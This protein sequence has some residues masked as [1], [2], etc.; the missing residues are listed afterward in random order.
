MIPL[1]FILL[2]F[3]ALTIFQSDKKTETISNNPPSNLPAEQEKGGLVT[4]DNPYSIEYLR[5]QDY[6][7]SDLVIEQTLTPGSNYNKFIASYKSEGLKIYALLTVPTSEKPAGGFPVILFNHGYI[8]PSQYRTAERYEAYV[9]AFARNGYI[10]L[11]SDYRGHGNSEGTAEGGHTSPAYTIDVLN[12]LSSIKKYENANPQKIGMW[13]HSMGGSIVLR[14]MELTNDIK[15]GVIW[16]GTVGPINNSSGR[17][18][19]GGTMRHGAGRLEQQFGTPETNPKFW[20]EIEPLNYLKDITAPIQL[21]HGTADEEVDPQVSADLNQKLK[22]SGKSVE[23]FT[24][25][26]DNHNLSNNLMTALNL[27]V[28]F[29]DKYLKN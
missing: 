15:A 5:K 2:G 16:A 3:L 14:A 29:F 23:Y 26:S 27:D 13:G 4:N 21:Q 11:K 12:A 25:E 18:Q 7:G 20:S 19:G 17:S 1:A 22:D 24:Y 10:V 8:Q 9:D 6:P 28:E